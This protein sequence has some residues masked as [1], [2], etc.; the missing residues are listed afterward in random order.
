MLSEQQ[1]R[2]L[3]EV[4]RQSVLVRIGISTT[5]PDPPH[6]L[7]DVSGVFVTLKNGGRLRGCLGVIDN[8]ASLGAEVIRCAADAASSDP[9]FAPMD[10]SELSTMTVE[11][12]VL[13]PLERI[14]PFSP[15]AITLGRHGLVIE[16][17]HRRGLLL[18]QVATEWGW[19]REEFLRN[20]CKKAN[21]PLDAWRQGAEVYRFDAEVFGDD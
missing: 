14:D 10:A 4:A 6:G 15:E 17:E 12:S 9:R 20:T 13:G 16:S 8:V 1:R 2:D 21:L 5:P 11:V 19:N 3:L 18:P 7:P